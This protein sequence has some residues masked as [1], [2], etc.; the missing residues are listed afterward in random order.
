MRIL[1]GSLLLLPCFAASAA[2][3]EHVTI[4]AVTAHLELPQ[5]YCR[6]S[7][8][9]A[10]ERQLYEMQDRVQN[11]INIVAV[12]AAPCDRIKSL[13]R[14]NM[15][16][17]YGIWLLQAP[18]GI[19]SHVPTSVT[20]EKVFDGLAKSIPQLDV[21]KISADIQ[22]RG[23]KE[24]IA[25]TVTASGLID[26]DQNG[27]YLGMTGR[28]QRAKG[29]ADIASV[30]G[31]TMIWGRRFSLNLYD[32]FTGNETFDRLLAAAKTALAKTA[33]ANPISAPESAGPVKALPP[34]MQ[35]VRPLPVD[36]KPAKPQQDALVLAAR[37]VP[38]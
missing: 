30:A 2:A 13:R 7:R 16:P 33:A 32:D 25:Y 26:K 1:V 15:P 34:G 5:G 11:G 8:S 37:S 17:Q 35:P 18:G 23:A 14:G 19:P 20:R 21:N 22:S 24:G 38:A 9:N 31:L 36:R 3:I 10:M 6:L 29:M 12:I 27:V 4:D 28:L